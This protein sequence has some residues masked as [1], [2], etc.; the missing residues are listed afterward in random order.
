MNLWPSLPA[1]RFQRR[2]D[3][4]LP[5]TRAWGACCPRVLTS[6]PIPSQSSGRS[7]SCSSVPSPATLNPQAIHISFSWDSLLRPFNQ[8]GFPSF[9]DLS[10]SS[11]SLSHLLKLPTS[12]THMVPP[13]TKGIHQGIRAGNRPRSKSHQTIHYRAY[14]PGS[15]YYLPRCGS[16]SN[17]SLKMD[18]RMMGGCMHTRILRLTFELLFL[19]LL[20]WSAIFWDWRTQL[21]EKPGGFK[22]KIAKWWQSLNLFFL[23]N[24]ESLRPTLV[25][26]CEPFHPTSCILWQMP[27]GFA[28]PLHHGI[29][30]LTLVSPWQ[31]AAPKHHLDLTQSQT[32]AL[33][34]ATKTARPFLLKVRNHGPNGSLMAFFANALLREWCVWCFAAAK[35]SFISGL[36]MKY[37]MLGKMTWPCCI[38][39]HPSLT[40]SVL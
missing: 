29:L 25:G 11:L 23:W 10:T 34:S 31:W 5:H 15:R 1:S 30:L 2:L 8:V 6:Q 27:R 28:Q 3:M 7:A 22:L 21:W 40:D 13:Y 16:R 19:V 33:V 26:A 38:M 17:K 37:W 35:T 39:L 24:R 4:S 9:P 32:S 12:G 14:G 36:G 18:G 20:L